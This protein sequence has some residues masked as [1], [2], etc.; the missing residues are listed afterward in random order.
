MFYW[1]IILVPI[2]K[3][4]IFLE[5]LFKHESLKFKGKIIDID[6]DITTINLL[7]FYSLKVAVEKERQLEYLIIYLDSEKDTNLNVGDEA[8]FFIRNNTIYA[9]YLGGDENG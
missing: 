4:I 3:R 8:T 9:Y 2:K 5:S 7:P 1:N 6:S